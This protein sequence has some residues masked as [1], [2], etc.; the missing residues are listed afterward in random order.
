M[1]KYV[2]Y[3]DEIDRTLL[4]QVGGKGA[5]LGEM[6]KAGFPVP[7]GFCVT[8]AAY[9]DFIGTCGEMDALFGLLDGVRYDDLASIREL[10]ERVRGRLRSLPIP[11]DIRAGILAAWRRTGE[12]KAYAVRSSATQRPATHRSRDSRKRA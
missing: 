8:T 4:S 9:R 10:G 11:D 1:V 3:F 6:A 12:D 5:S 2:L 7:G